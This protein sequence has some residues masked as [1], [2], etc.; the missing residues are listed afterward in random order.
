VAS[1]LKCSFALVASI[2]I[3]DLALPSS[4]SAITVE[5]ARQCSALA[6]KAYPPVVAGNPAAGR[7]NGTAQDLREYFNKCVANGGKMPT[8]EQPSNKTDQGPGGT[9]SES[10][11]PK[12]LKGQ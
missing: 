6:N 4:A 8:S 12:E 1:T 3:A 2:C 11:P 10:Q 9:G 7:E 5:V